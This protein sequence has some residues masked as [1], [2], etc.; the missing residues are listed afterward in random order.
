[1]FAALLIVGPVS[2]LSMTG[3]ALVDGPRSGRAK[4]CGPPL[5]HLVG[6]VSVGGADE[7]LAA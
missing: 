4:W 2:P 6:Y 1:M 3:I 7:Y 5:I